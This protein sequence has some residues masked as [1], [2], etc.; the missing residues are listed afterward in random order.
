[1]NQLH[2]LVAVVTVCD[3]VV[4]HSAKYWQSAIWLSGGSLEALSY[5]QPRAQNA[6]ERAF[7]RDIFRSIGSGAATEGN[8]INLVFI[9]VSTQYATKQ[10]IRSKRKPGRPAR[11][12]DPIIAL[13]V[14]AQTIRAIDKWGGEHASRSEAIRTLIEIGLVSKRKR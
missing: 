9:T 3:R 1:M 8:Y 10:I 12:K 4:V 14:P 5:W 11:G 2:G 6:T 13:R 7:R